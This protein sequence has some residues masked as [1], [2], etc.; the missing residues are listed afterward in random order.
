[1]EE[2]R[3]IALLRQGDLRGLEFLV[4]RY[5]LQATRA[6]F[7]VLGDRDQAEDI[8]QAAFLRA[9]QRIGQLRG[10]RFGPWFLRSVV[11]DAVKTAKKQK[12]FVALDGE[13]DDD[14]GA[15]ARWLVD[16]GAGLEELVLRGEEQRAVRAALQRLAPGQRAALVMRYYLEMSE[17]EM[18][19]VLGLPLSTVK[20]R[21]FRA[22]ERLRA[23]LGGLRKE[24]K[25]DEP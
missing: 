10:E 15:L 16:P 7:L 24:E 18:T 23:W 13:S 1:M 11:N 19:G 6:A 3:A 17:A 22:R 9:A 4:H 14:A 2:H 8:V 5:Y 25:R 21:L 20:G 12:R